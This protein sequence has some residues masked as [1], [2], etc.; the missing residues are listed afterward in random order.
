MNMA[1]NGSHGGLLVRV[2][3]VGGMKRYRRIADDT[4]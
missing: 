3:A 2:I 1:S 4:I